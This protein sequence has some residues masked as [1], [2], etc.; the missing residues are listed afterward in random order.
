[1]SEKRN[2]PEKTGYEKYVQRHSHKRQR[3]QKATDLGK[4]I[5]QSD[6]ALSSRLWSIAEEIN[7]A[8]DIKLIRLIGPT[9]A[10]K[11]TAAK[12]LRERFELL[13][14]HLHV[15]SIDDFYYNTDVLREMSSDNSAVDYDSPETIDIPELR[16]FVNE[17]FTEDRSRC[18]VFDF[19]VGR[20]NGFKE[21]L[22]TDDDIFLFEG[23]QVLYPV[24]SEI[25]ASVGHPSAEI[26]IA[27]QS[28]I[29]IGGSVFEPN[30]LR[31][32]RRLVRDKIYRNT[33]AEFTFDLWQNVRI[34]EEKNIFP[35]VGACKYRIDSTM[36]YEIGVLKPHL[37]RILG[38]LPRGSKY[39][40]EAEEILKKIEGI[41]PIPD[42]LIE[43]GSLYKEFV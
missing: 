41:L 18:P 6:A 10:G 14:K 29:S 11:T 8:G 7:G 36:P 37:V 3:A 4:W 28:S 43:D 2:M 31:L 1:M 17:I 42:S 27:P 13:G 40:E 32:M 39:T 21:Y 26:Y 12:M 25:F 16:R 9:C 23:I 22:C 33:D 30:E 38:E 5:A 20:R 15:I 35:Y 34:N 19:N 24:V